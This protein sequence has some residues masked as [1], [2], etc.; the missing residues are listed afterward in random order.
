MAHND[1]SLISTPVFRAEWNI[2]ERLLLIYE[3]T[4]FLM[5]SD[6]RQE[7]K[8]ASVWNSIDEVSEIAP[9]NHTTYLVLA[10]VVRQ[11]GL[12]LGRARTVRRAL[13]VNVA[14]AHHYEKLIKFVFS[15]SRTDRCTRYITRT[16]RSSRSARPWTMRCRAVRSI[17][18]HRGTAG[19]S[20]IFRLAIFGKHHHHIT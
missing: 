3:N 2:I 6:C 14:I 19:P 10:L 7:R 1:W 17:R 15:I 12:R 8:Q 4:H 5:I 18:A 20:A 11:I 9:C 16:S 13:S